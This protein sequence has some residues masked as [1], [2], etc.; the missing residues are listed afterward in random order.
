MATVPGHSGQNLGSFSDL[1]LYIE[2]QFRVPLVTR[3]PPI[4]FFLS[5]YQ[6]RVASL[7]A[8]GIARLCERW[9]SATPTLLSDGSPM[10]LR[11]EFAQLALASARELQLGRAKGIIYAGDEDW[12]VR[13]Y[14]AALA[15]AHD[16][17]V[18]ISDW[19]LEMAQRRP[20][21]AD[22]QEKVREH[23][24]DRAAEH[25]RR[26]QED[27]AYRERHEQI[28]RLPPSLSIRKP[29]PPWPL[30][31][32][33]R[34]ETQF[35]EA[36]LRSASFR[37]LMEANAAVAAEVLLACIIEDQP[38]EEYGSVSELDHEIGIEADHKGYA[39]APWKSPFL[40]FFQ[41]NWA[42]AFECLNQLTNFAT[43]RWVL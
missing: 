38:E 35:R 11:R 20:Y 22:I 16:L 33:G 14:Q 40:S 43:E 28:Q 39:T 41:F 1:S 8:P 29:L 9:L 37:A 3:W 13:I 34:I 36:V 6:D 2:T 32:A 42:A 7:T 4:A 25:A 15:G 30:G 19:A 31:P 27:T 5:K 23:Y 18:E 24:R 17:P 26:M 12:E 10:P 21:R